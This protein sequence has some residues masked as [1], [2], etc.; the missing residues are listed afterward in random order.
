MVLI[1]I[2]VGLLIFYTPILNKILFPNGKKVFDII[3]KLSQ[4]EFG[5]DVTGCK[6]YLSLKNGII[7]SLKKMNR[8]DFEE[9][10]LSTVANIEHLK[11][12]DFGGYM[13]TKFAYWAIILAVIS[14]IY[15][16]NIFEIIGLSKIISLNIV[17]IIF[18]IFLLIMGRTIRVQ[19]NQL[20]YLNFKLMCINII[21][22]EREN[23][24]EQIQKKIIE[25][26]HK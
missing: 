4:V 26:N 16:G 15:D 11:E 22:C 6:N 1:F 20:E 10:A 2:V 25:K 24:K 23:N 21:K 12:N 7:S 8:Q 9:N 17:M 5:K 3:H 13:T 18:T 14:T 19:H